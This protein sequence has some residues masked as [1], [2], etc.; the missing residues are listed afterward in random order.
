MSNKL[1]QKWATALGGTKDAL[2]NPILSASK[3]VL[4]KINVLKG[5]DFSEAEN[6]LKRGYAPR[7]KM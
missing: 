5:N 2:W 3:N 7:Y 6:I 1:F 4:K